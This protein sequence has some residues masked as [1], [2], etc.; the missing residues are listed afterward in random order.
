MQ[1]MNEARL[2]LEIMEMK[3]RF[4]S[5]R[6]VSLLGGM[7]GFRGSLRPRTSVYEIL[8]VLPP[9]YPHEAPRVFPVFPQIVSPKHQYKSGALCYHLS[10][11]WSPQYT[12]CVAIG[13]VSHW[14][15]AHEQFV[16]T[17]H[18]PGKEAEQ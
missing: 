5:F 2:Q 3:K 13:W 11:E 17:G 6:V 8:V 1:Q 4:P 7:L 12:V 18:W 15:A 16:K 9:T 10:H 14:L